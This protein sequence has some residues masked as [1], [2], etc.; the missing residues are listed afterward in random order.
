M[1][2]ACFKPS[3][4]YF[5][6]SYDSKDT[7]GVGILPHLIDHSAL[8]CS[9]SHLYRTLPC[10]QRVATVLN[11]ADPFHLYASQSFL[12][13][14]RS[15]IGKRPREIQLLPPRIKERLCLF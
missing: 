1:P 8:L 10:L 4:K 11:S 6:R 9:C 14:S 5:S 2:F 3:K 12:S 15:L 13:I 7:L